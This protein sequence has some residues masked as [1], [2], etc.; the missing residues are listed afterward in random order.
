MVEAG[1]ETLRHGGDN[2]YL[3][4]LKHKLQSFRVDIGHSSRSVL[5]APVKSELTLLFLDDGG[6]AGVPQGTGYLGDMEVLGIS[7]Q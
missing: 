4:A 2:K 5:E 1:K 3:A 7:E 6:S